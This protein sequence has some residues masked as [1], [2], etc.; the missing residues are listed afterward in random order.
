MAGLV[1]LPKEF[2]EAAAEFADGTK[3]P[4]EPRDEASALAAAP[5]HGA[6]ELKGVSFR[7]A[8][9]VPLLI[10][11][12]NLRIEAGEST[13]IIT[14]EGAQG[15]V[16]TAAN[17]EQVHDA[18]PTVA[19]VTKEEKTKTAKPAKKEKGNGKGKR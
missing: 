14:P 16:P 17:A 12:V 1:G 10:D 19:E 5:V 8:E 3:T 18:A 15:A 9:S 4:A 2:A 7:Y 11:G 13:I 6:I